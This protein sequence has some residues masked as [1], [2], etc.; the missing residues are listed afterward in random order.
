MQQLKIQK[1]YKSYYTAREEPEVVEIS[2]MTYISILGTGSP[3]TNIF[4]RKKKAIKSFVE[5]LGAYAGLEKP[6]ASSIIEIFYWYDEENV[7]FVNI[8][9]FYTTV[10]LDMLHYRMAIR[11]PEYVSEKDFQEVVK[12]S[13]NAFANNFQ[14]FTYTAGK[15]VQLLHKGAFAGELDTLPVLQQF[16]T[17][18]GLKKSG[19]HHEIHLVDFEKG[20]DQ[21][22]LRTI[23]R[24]PVR[25]FL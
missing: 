8:G 7:G 10:D 6:F 4:Y 2:E 13:K 21:T 25:T 9:D 11:I 20:Q 24:D 17:D 14:F 16:A 18:N 12:L 5:E 19:L 22:H 15:C 3:G 1:E 23:L